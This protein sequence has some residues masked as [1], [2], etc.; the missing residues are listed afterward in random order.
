MF[1]RKG[2][3]MV[4]GI[5]ALV[6][7]L[8]AIVLVSYV[9]KTEL[10]PKKPYE[11]SLK[12]EAK[13]IYEK[14][15]GGLTITIYKTP[16]FVENPADIKDALVTINFTPTPDVDVNSI[17]ITDVDGNP[18]PSEFDNGTKTLKW[19]SDLLDSTGSNPPNTFYL[20]Y[21]KDT[22]LPEYS[23]GG[24]DVVNGTTE[25]Y[26]SAD[27]MI[28]YFDTTG[29]S[30]LYYLYDPPLSAPVEKELTGS[31]GI[32]FSTAGPFNFSYGGLEGKAI[33]EDTTVR[34]VVDSTKFFIDTNSTITFDLKDFN[35]IYI[36]SSNDPEN[37]ITIIDFY[38]G[39]LVD[40]SASGIDA[41][42]AIAIIGVLDDYV[43]DIEND[44]I[45]INASAFEVYIHT[46]NHTNALSQYASY[47]ASPETL[48]GVTTTV[49]GIFEQKYLDLASLTE[50]E[51]KDELNI[52]ETSLL[53][54]LK[55]S[56]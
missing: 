28:L 45:I 41:Q 12:A 36:E 55:G 15:E 40:L 24:L 17:S 47:S 13:N 53:I 49:A 8:S 3:V 7:F 32:T 16:V 26:I 4:G 9:I 23:Y 48:L 10:M 38:S 34:V 44:T 35:D 30:S 1:R 14:I 39:P 20:A 11:S 56:T 21:M 2:Q 18:I 22:D 6:I 50:D 25:K 43:A 46:G 52:S 42:G 33:Y 19:Y 5:I 37:N 31:A 27:D 54:Y 29:I 51:L